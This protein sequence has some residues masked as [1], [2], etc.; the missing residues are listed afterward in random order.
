MTI[1]S[2][3]LLACLAP[4]PICKRC[5]CPAASPLPP[6]AHASPTP[7]PVC[8]SCPA[9]PLPQIFFEN[10]NHWLYIEQADEFNKL[11]ADFAAHGF[12]NVSKVLHI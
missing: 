9:T 5:L 10:A 1:H 12:L 7:V 3:C 2:L 6:A 4:A 8:A 11:V